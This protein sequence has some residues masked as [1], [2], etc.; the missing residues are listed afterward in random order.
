MNK[1]KIFM[2]KNNKLMI[3]K[4]SSAYQGKGIK[5]V[6]KFDEI[7]KHVEEYNNK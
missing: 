5:V 3:V 1:I 7:L 2:E 4:P 6:R